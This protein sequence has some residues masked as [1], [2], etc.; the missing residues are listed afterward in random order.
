[1]KKAAREKS[2]KDPGG[3]HQG[4]DEIIMSRQ[5]ESVKSPATS[6]AKVNNTIGKLRSNMSLYVL[7]CRDTDK[8]KV[9]EIKVEMVK[10]FRELAGRTEEFFETKGM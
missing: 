7:A 10:L 4:K 2:T 9:E 8:Q 5:P 3:R 6:V 1:M